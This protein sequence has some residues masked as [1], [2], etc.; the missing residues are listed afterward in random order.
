[1]EAD[2]VEGARVGLDTPEPDDAGYVGPS[3]DI[4]FEIVSYVR[5]RSFRLTDGSEAPGSVQTDAWRH[6]VAPAGEHA[7]LPVVLWAYYQACRDVAE[8]QT[9]DLPWERDMPGWRAFAAAMRAD[10]DRPWWW[11]DPKEGMQRAQEVFSRLAGPKDR[12]H[13]SAEPRTPGSA[14][15]QFVTPEGYR[16]SVGRSPAPAETATWGAPAPTTWQWDPFTRQM[17]SAR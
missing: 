4:E 12:P 7:L 6:V 2:I 3:V 5:P 16:V 8:G 14:V 15:Q 13:P 1:M 11:P 9:A 17:R 10:P